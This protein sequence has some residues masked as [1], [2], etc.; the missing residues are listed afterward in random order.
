MCD[1][2][3]GGASPR[4]IPPVGRERCQLYHEVK[5]DT[6]DV[7]KEKGATLS[8]LASTDAV[9]SAV[10][11]SLQT[12]STSVDGSGHMDVSGGKVM[13]ELLCGVFRRPPRQ[14]SREDDV[15]PA[16][17]R[18]LDV[19]GRPSL[20]QCICGRTRSPWPEANWRHFSG[21]SSGSEGYRF[22]DI[23]LGIL[24]HLCGTSF[25]ALDH[26]EPIDARG[27]VCSMD[28][29]GVDRPILE[30]GMIPCAAVLG[31][32]QYGIV[33]R[34]RSRRTREVFAVKVIT[35]SGGDTMVTERERDIV[36]LVHK[37]PHPCLVKLHSIHKSGNDRL[38]AIVMEYCSA[39]D[40]QFHI[41]SGRQVA[42]LAD[43]HY[44]APLSSPA[45]IGQ[46]FLGLEHV[47]KQMGILYRD[48]KPLNIVIN[49]DGHAKLTDF[50][51]G[52]HG[53]T[54]VGTWS[55][56]FPAGSPGFTAP[57]ILD[58]EE[59]DFRADLYAFGVLIWI[60]LTGGV[61]DR[62]EP[63]PPVNYIDDDIELFLK[64]LHD[65]ASNNA[66]PIPGLAAER[67]VIGLT[68]AVAALRPDHA[69]IRENPLLKA[70][71]MPDEGADIVD[72]QVWLS[73]CDV[74]I[75]HRSE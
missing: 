38:E 48:L 9:S 41:R 17:A 53:L 61:T 8:E 60:L 26:L 57:E 3:F 14:R 58:Q 25:L 15:S 50:G 12:S 27:V 49:A 54:S 20:G 32:G 55:F 46:I 63:M 56:G 67:L 69:E 4:V 62:D 10:P 45:W 34:A 66:L 75:E 39:G 40:L 31:E 33:Y 37:V 42:A 35:A 18:A 13:R 71:D 44:V 28:F 5:K 70:L 64:C 74:S 72:F 29:P 1:L 73:R 68:Q 36:E 51:L 47:H 2:S 11:S 59:Y 43:G 21:R 24:R 23:T 7:L 19:E 52:R 6:V 30:P 16:G 22:G 65:P